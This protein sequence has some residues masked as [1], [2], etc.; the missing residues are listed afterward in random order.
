[1]SNIVEILNKHAL[2]SDFKI[3]KESRYNTWILNAINEITESKDQQIKDL[4]ELLSFAKKVIPSRED[5][6]P[7]YAVHRN[8][9]AIKQVEYFEKYPK[10]Q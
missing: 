5:E 2:Q 3:D 10:Q 4:E 8:N 6:L 1:M 7:M 9:F